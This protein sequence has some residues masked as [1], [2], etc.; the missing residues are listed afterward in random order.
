MAVYIVTYDLRSESSSADYERLISLIKEEG[1]WA[2]LGG[3]SYLIESDKTAKELR[4]KYCDILDENDMLYVGLASAPAAWHGYSK[5]VS[6]W[7]LKKLD[8]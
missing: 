5:A 2:C 8:K 1:S 6:E 7:I 4:D 3:S